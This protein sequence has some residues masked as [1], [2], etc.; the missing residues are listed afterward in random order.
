M[1]TENTVINQYAYTS[2]ITKYNTC[3]FFN[4]PFYFAGPEICNDRYEIYPAV[5]DVPRSAVMYDVIAETTASVCKHLCTNLKDET[6][7]GI[8]YDPTTRTCIMTS[9]TAEDHQ[10]HTLPTEDGCDK[11]LAKY[12]RRHRCLC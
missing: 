6:C 1:C 11:T 10:M 5:C 4:V 7:S 3:R 9:F 2:M 12:Y 8:L